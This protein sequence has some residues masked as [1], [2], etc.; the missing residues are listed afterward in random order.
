MNNSKRKKEE[1]RITENSKVRTLTEDPI[2]HEYNKSLEEANKDN[3]SKTSK[4]VIVH[5]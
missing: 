4:T 3:K 2:L 1:Q 5:G